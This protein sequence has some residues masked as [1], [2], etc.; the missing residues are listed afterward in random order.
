MKQGGSRRAIALASLLVML[1]ATP[2]ARAEDMRGDIL[3]YSPGTTCS[4]GITVGDVW[5]QCLCETE[6]VA[7]TDVEEALLGEDGCRWMLRNWRVWM[8]CDC[9]EDEVPLAAPEPVIARDGQ[10]TVRSALA[11]IPISEHLQE[12]NRQR[13]GSSILGGTQ[14]GTENQPTA[15]VAS[16]QMM[17]LPGESSTQQAAD[18]QVISTEKRTQ[19]AVMGIPVEVAEAARTTT[20]ARQPEGADGA[21]ASVAQALQATK[22][23]ADSIVSWTDLDKEEAEPAEKSSVEAGRQAIADYTASVTGLLGTVTTAPETIVEPETT[24]EPD[25][26]EEPE[27]VEEPVP[28]PEVEEEPEELVTLSVADGRRL[29]EMEG[30]T[31]DAQLTWMLT[32]DTSGVWSTQDGKEWTLQNVAGVRGTWRALNREL[33]KWTPVD[34]SGEITGTFANGAN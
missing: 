32:G 11:Q 30:S 1:A 26:V 29:M 7:L 6:K 34:G 33:W 15:K 27:A 28:E 3:F 10:E 24:A 13:T 21:Q 23:N 19:Q 31:P 25:A 9:G 5:F 14:T 2:S 16:T 20:T 17:G 18:A 12:G 22:S 8:R 4:Q